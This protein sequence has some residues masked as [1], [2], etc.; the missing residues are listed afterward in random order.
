MMNIELTPD[1]PKTMDFLIRFYGYLIPS[2]RIGTNLPEV[3]FFD[4]LVRVS[5][6]E[7]LDFE[8]NKEAAIIIIK[9]RGMVI[10]KNQ[11]PGAIQPGDNESFVGQMFIPMEMLSHLDCLTDRITGET[12]NHVDG[13]NVVGQGIE[14]KELKSN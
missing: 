14:K 10:W 9:Q 11:N 13:Q 7:Q 12:P 5:S 4:K 6:H 3:V 8:V 2:K 1:G